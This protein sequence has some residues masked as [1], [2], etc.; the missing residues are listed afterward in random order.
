VIKPLLKKYLL[1]KVVDNISRIVYTY[2]VV[3]KRTEPHHRGRKG[4]NHD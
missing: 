4:V 2:G 3:K 1:K